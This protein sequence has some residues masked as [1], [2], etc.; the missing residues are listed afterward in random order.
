MPDINSNTLEKDLQ[1][2]MALKTSSSFPD[3]HNRQGKGG[4][5]TQGYVKNSHIDKPLITVITVVFNGKQILETTIK[6]VLAQTYDNVE[7]L[8]IDGSSSDGTLDIIKKYEKQ[9]DYWVSE[10]DGGIYDAM[11]KAIS[12]ANGKWIN[13]MN[14]GDTFFNKDTL[15]NLFSS[16]SYDDIDI[17][18]GDHEVRYPHKTRIARAGYISEIWKASQFSHQSV[19][20][21]SQYHKSHLYNTCIKITSDFAFFYNAYIKDAKFHY[22]DT[23]ISSITSGGI[24]DVKRVD[25]ILEMWMVQEKSTKLNLYY[26]FRIFKE[27][28]KEKVKKVLNREEN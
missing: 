7:Y 18:Y 15:T 3:E 16:S 28:L 14:A 21:S 24:S 17:L 12:L 11:N 26:I 23:V 6:S 20:I 1:R 22:T 2:K 13:F 10:K 5:R 8:I 4:L 25:G 27:I 9:I 19:F